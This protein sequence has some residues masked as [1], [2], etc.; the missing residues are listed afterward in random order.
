MAQFYIDLPLRSVGTLTAPGLAS[1]GTLNLILDELEKKADLNEEQLVLGPLTDAE[2]RAT[3]V[4]VTGEFTVEGVSQESTQLDVFTKLDESLNVQQ[5]T[6][7]H[8]EQIAENTGSGVRFQIDGGSVLANYDTTTPENSTAL[9][10]RTIG[11]AT[12]TK[13]DTLQTSMGAPV[14]TMATDYFGT[15]SLIALIKR[16]GLYLSSIDTQMATK[17]SATKQDDQI[18]LLGAISG[19]LPTSLGA[20]TSALSLSMTPAS[21][22][23]F[24]FAQQANQT[25]SFDED[26]TVSTTPET[27][28]A[29][30]GAFACLI[31]ADETNTT[32][33]RVKMGG[34]SSPTSGT[35][36]QG[37]R[38]ELYEGGSNISYCTE[39]GTGK[40]SA[41]WFVRT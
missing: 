39:S 17:A 11:G 20:K 36:F 33:I 40:I 30:A 13:Q 8:I 5:I 24:K 19:K 23:I 4:E 28:V 31:S 16:L 37:G 7:Q 6:Q 22:A 29:P 9:P 35:Q 41:Q 15:F 1:E 3:P 32:N 21:D 10:V 38:S 18:V 34:T 26:N 27:F 12:A 14:D 25:A 2:L